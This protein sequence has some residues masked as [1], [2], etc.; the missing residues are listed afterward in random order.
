MSGFSNILNES[1]VFKDVH[2]HLK[3]PENNY[4]PIGCLYN[5]TV[6]VWEI[7][8]FSVIKNRFLFILKQISL[9]SFQI[10]EGLPSLCNTTQE[11]MHII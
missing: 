10:W 2:L 7:D 1:T 5:I 9:F 6:D 3:S 11:N 4:Y 8:T